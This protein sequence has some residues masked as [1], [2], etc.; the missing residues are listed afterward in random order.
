MVCG[1]IFFYLYGQSTATGVRGRIGPLAV[2]HVTEDLRRV[3]ATALVL[4][5]MQMA[6][7]SVRE[8]RINELS[9]IRTNAKVKT[10]VFK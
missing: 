9:A 5:L 6:D 1:I 2:L 8:T 10:Q 3:I 7:E 4:H